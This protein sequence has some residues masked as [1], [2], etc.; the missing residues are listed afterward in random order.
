MACMMTALCSIYCFTI[1]IPAKSFGVL[2]LFAVLAGSVCGTFW[3]TVTAVTAEVVGLQ[4]LPSTFGI[5]CMGLVL[6]TTF[7]EPLALQIVA[8]SGYLTSQIF[9]GILFLLGALCLFLL[10]SWK[11]DQV[12]LKARQTHDPERGVGKALVWLKPSKFFVS[13]HV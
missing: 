12:E 10:R 5:I 13:R 2:V 4:R 6:P 9:V 7:A 1:W 3:G 8:A 11:I